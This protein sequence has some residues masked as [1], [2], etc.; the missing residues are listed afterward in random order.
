MLKKILVPVLAFLF[1]ICMILLN[2]ASRLSSCQSEKRELMRSTNTRIK[3]LVLSYS[4]SG[5]SLLGE[6]LSLDPSSSYYFEP[7]YQHKL[8]CEQ[9]ANSSSV[10]IQKLV[11]Y[12]LGGLFNCKN[13]RIVSHL[14]RFLF[15]NFIKK[16]V[17]KTW[18]L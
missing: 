16:K 3:I 18:G 15:H 10:F 7:L 14:H 12:Y 9:R 1:M 17:S 2:T 8:T 6:L 11:N 4:R 5:S 13:R